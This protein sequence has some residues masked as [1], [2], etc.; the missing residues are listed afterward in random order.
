M[1]ARPLLLA[2]A[3]GDERGRGRAARSTPQPLSPHLAAELAGETLDPTRWLSGRAPRGGRR[4]D[5]VVEGVGGLLVPLA[6]D[7]TVRDLAARAGA[8]ARDR[9]TPR[10]S[11]RSTTRCSR[12]RPRGRRADVTAVVLTP[13]AREPSDDSNAP[14]ARRSRGSAQSRSRRSSECPSPAGGARP[15]GR[16]APVAPLALSVECL[17]GPPERA[18]RRRRCARCVS[19]ASSIARRHGGLRS[20]S[21]DHVRAASHR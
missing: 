16:G 3:A 20:S 17:P 8:S 18:L 7:Y 14:T 12:S 2:S 10:R 9:R 1:A 15:G 11:A 19:A 5:A 13:V 21:L 6:E 4:A